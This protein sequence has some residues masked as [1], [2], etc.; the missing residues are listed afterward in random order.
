MNKKYPGTIAF[1]ANESWSVYIFRLGVINKFMSLGYKVVVISPQDYG[2][3]KLIA[4]GITY[5]PMKLDNYSKNPLQDLK[6][7]FQ[8]FQLYRKY[9]PDFI[10]HYNL[11]PNIYGSLAARLLAIPC[12]AVT[13]GLGPLFAGK[14]VWLK[15]LVIRLYKIATKSCKE[16]WFL[17]ESDRQEFIHQKIVRRERAFLLKSEGVNIKKFP[18]SGFHLKTDSRVTF[19]FAGRL[20][21][22]KGVGI[23]VE[24]AKILKRKHPL[25]EFQILG[26]IHSNNPDAVKAPQI[27]QWQREGWITYKGET[28]QVQPFIAAADCVVLPS[29]YREGVPR[30]LLEAASMAKPIITTDHVGCKE[31]VDHGVNGFLCQPKSISDLVRKMEDFLLLSDDERFKMGWEGRK[32]VEREFDEAAIISLYLKKLNEF[33]RDYSKVS[34][35]VNTV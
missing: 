17:N 18:P 26:F 11:K 12:V 19:L 8:L 30:I 9:R 32:K 13:T 15:W 33:K 29:F 16:I 10:F 35:Q 7:F 27:S 20:I 6:T 14:Y 22:D 34:K 24:A 4:Q 5:H 23:F 21:W 31:V 28:L 2:S 25:V 3:S 1:V